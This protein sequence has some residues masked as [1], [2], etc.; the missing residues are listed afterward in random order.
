MLT[1]EQIEYSCSFYCLIYRDVSSI[2]S[3]VVV[4]VIAQPLNDAK[5]DTEIDKSEDQSMNKQVS[6]PIKIISDDTHCI[7]HVLMLK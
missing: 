5:V 3:D 6:C 7:F 1:D 2:G 4:N